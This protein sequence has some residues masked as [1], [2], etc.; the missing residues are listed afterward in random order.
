MVPPVRS[1]IQPALYPPDM[2]RGRIPITISMA[3]QQSPHLPPIAAVVGAIKMS[4]KIY[5]RTVATIRSP[6]RRLPAALAVRVDR[7]KF[8]SAAG[9]R[10]RPAYRCPHEEGAD[11]PRFVT[12]WI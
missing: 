6:R 12:E 9:G 5:K 4:A 1:R 10:P 3:K 2:Q 7:G 11:P 8:H